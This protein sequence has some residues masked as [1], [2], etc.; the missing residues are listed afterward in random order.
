[1]DRL[2]QSHAPAAAKS[3]SHVVHRGVVWA[4]RVLGR[5]LEEVHDKVA[6]VL[7]GSSNPFTCILG[8]ASNCLTGILCRVDDGLAGISCHVAKV[9]HGRIPAFLSDVL[10][11]DST[12]DSKTSHSY[13]SCTACSHLCSGAPAFLLFFSRGS[14][15]SRS[16][17]C[18]S[19]IRQRRDIPKCPEKKRDFP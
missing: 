16:S 3:S 8:C 4:L 5:L 12:S 15:G 1:M 6:D 13:N 19:W 7:C 17:G 2:L 10:A 18:C 14:R 11:E 9:R